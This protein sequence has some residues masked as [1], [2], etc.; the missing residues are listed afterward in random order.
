LLADG[1][2]PK[3]GD[4]TMLWTVL[5]VVMAIFVCAPCTFAAEWS[6]SPQ[7]TTME[8]YNNNIL[9]SQENKIDDFV[10]YIQPRLEGAYRTNRL[11]TSLNAGLSIEKYIDHEDL[12]TVDQDYRGS[13][14][15]ALFQTFS[16][17]AGGFFRRDTTLETELFEAGLLYNREDR[18]LYGGNLGCKYI[19]SPR[20]TFSGA[21]YRS[22]T[23]YPGH[24]ADLQG[25]RTDSLDFIAEYMFNPR[26]IIF[27]NFSYTISDYDPE[28]AGTFEIT[29]RSIANYTFMPSFRHYF[30]ETSYISAGIG[31]RYTDSESKIVQKPPFDQFLSNV[32]VNEQTNGFIYSVAVHKDWEKGSLEFAGGRDQYSSLDGISYTQDR[33]SVNGTYKLS[34]R[35][36][37]SGNASYSRST[38]DQTQSSDEHQY[39]TVSPAVSYSW[40]PNITLKGSV[41]YS[42][43]LPQDDSD[44]DRFT[45][46]LSLIVA[47]PKYLKGS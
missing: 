39:F 4:I 41:D 40:T 32:D 29:D 23:E 21:W 17:E 19:F 44:Y 16:V 37:G 27:G 31:F 3:E 11:E 15:Y 34:A 10:T 45:A 33:F 46:M 47:W 20:L 18:R 30:A 28:D 25:Y 43:Y 2:K 24:P 1:Q 13:F 36:I 7:L 26:N 12:D 42:R 6:V 22:Y 5:T 38:A 14:S 35:F 9:F 8:Q